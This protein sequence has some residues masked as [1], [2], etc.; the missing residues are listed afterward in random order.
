M[1]GWVGG[2]P[3]PL[4]GLGIAALAAKEGHELWI[5]EDFCAH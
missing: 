5:T 1:R 2:G 3:D 4:A